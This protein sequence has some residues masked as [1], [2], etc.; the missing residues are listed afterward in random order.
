MY[1]SVFKLFIV[2]FDYSICGPKVQSFQTFLFS[3]SAL[4]HL[5]AFRFVLGS[6]MSIL[7]RAV[8]CQAVPEVSK[9]ADVEAEPE[10]T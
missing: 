9:P 2:G 1:V 5:P 3:K 10:E 6:P 8:T 4:F 7:S